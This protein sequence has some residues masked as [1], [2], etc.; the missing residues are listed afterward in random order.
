[1]TLEVLDLSLVLLGGFAGIEGAEVAAFV[2]LRVD[3]AGIDS[4]FAGFQF[5]D[6][7]CWTPQRRR[8]IPNGG[9]RGSM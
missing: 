1:M 6:H 3:L 2:G 4:I 5:S 7:D 8:V 9:P